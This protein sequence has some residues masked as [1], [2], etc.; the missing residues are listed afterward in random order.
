MDYFKELQ[1][2]R[3]SNN[4]MQAMQM[5]QMKMPPTMGAGTLPQGVMSFNDREQLEPMTRQDDKE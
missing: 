3:L 4:S 1:Q 2:P 5:Q